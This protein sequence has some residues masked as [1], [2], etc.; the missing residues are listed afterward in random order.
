MS[1]NKGNVAVFL[2][3]LLA[4]TDLFEGL[5]SVRT[6]FRYN[7]QSLVQTKNLAL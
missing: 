2:R 6:C 1:Q 7:R 4:I 3:K 5:W